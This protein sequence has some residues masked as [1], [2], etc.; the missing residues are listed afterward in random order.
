MSDFDTF[1]EQCIQ[2]A[3]YAAHFPPS[4]VDTLNTVMTVL[5][6]V[7]GCLG[8]LCGLLFDRRPPDRQ[9]RDITKRSFCVMSILLIFTAVP[10]ALWI[11]L[12][13]YYAYCII[14]PLSTLHWLSRLCVLVI[15]TF[16]LLVGIANWLYLATR[17]K[18]EEMRDRLWLRRCW[19]RVVSAALL[20]VF[21]SP[22]YP[23]LWYRERRGKRITRRPFWDI[24]V[25]CAFGYNSRTSNDQLK[26]LHGRSGSLGSSPA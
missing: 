19:G 9:T 4:K 22:A 18:F 25:D 20:I 11:P 10:Y 5:M 24:I 13:Q 21:L 12:F 2:Q 26:D 17:V 23:L 7:F 8:T 14:A 1:K 6:V 16:L 3:R 15:G